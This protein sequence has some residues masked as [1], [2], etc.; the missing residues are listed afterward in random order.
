MVQHDSN[1]IRLI[2][3]EDEVTIDLEYNENYA[4]LHMPSVGVFNKS[5]YLKMKRYLEGLDTFFT[6]VGYDGIYAATGNE[7]AQKLAIKLGFEYLGEHDNLKVY[8]YGSYPS[9][10][11]SS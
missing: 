3:F 7:S 6:T 10:N 4:I 11:H 5:L 9:S 1:R 8:K 2:E